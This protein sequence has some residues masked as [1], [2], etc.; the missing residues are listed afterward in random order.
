MQQLMQSRLVSTHMQTRTPY[1]PTFRHRQ[2]VHPQAGTHTLTYTRYC[3]FTAALLLQTQTARTRR[4]RHKHTHVHSRT[5]IWPNPFQMVSTNTLQCILLKTHF[6]MWCVT[7]MVSRLKKAHTSR[8][9]P[10]SAYLFQSFAL[11]QLIPESIL[12]TVTHT[13]IE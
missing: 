12:R 1:Q 9:H 7:Q 13:F 11:V 3:C 2:H 5:E 4:S 8:A 10:T 6:R